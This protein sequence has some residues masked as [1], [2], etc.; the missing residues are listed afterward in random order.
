M[1]FP[2]LRRG[3]SNNGPP[4]SNPTLSL[5][6][7]PTQHKHTST[8]TETHTLTFC[9]LW[10]P[11]WPLPTHLYYKAPK[12]GPG[13]VFI[14][15]CAHVNLPSLHMQHLQVANN[16][17]ENGTDGEEMKQST[18]EVAKCKCLHVC[19]SAKR[20]ARGTVGAWVAER[21]EQKKQRR[22]MRSSALPVR[23]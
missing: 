2:A 7:G 20:K 23:I 19:G 15:M 10:G 18:Y 12:I 22:E 17:E 21:D 1:R 13:S 11:R 5:A 9:S 6:H 14:C 4:A 8:H 16:G 3:V